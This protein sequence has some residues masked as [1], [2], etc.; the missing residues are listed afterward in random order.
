MKPAAL[1]L[2]FCIA[3]Q[4]HADRIEGVA[5][6]LYHGDHD[7]L[8]AVDEIAALGASHVSLAVFWRQRDVRSSSLGPDPKV[9]IA[10]DR[11]RA[12]VRRAHER[13]L[14]VLLFPII[15][16]DV[17]KRGEWRG[18]LAPA[19]REAW[20]RSYETFILHYARLAAEEKIAI[21]SVGS[22]LGS[23][24][25]WQGRWWH[26][27]GK[28]ERLYAGELLYSANWDHYRAPTFWQRL[29]YVGVSAYF[30]L[31]KRRDAPREELAT[32][33]QTALAEIGRFAASVEKR[34]VLTEVGLPSR[35]G[36]AMAPWDYTREGPIDLEEQRLGYQAFLD[37]WAKERIAGA[38][39]WHW[40][41]AGGP[42]DGGYSPRGKPAAE[43]LRRA[44]GGTGILAP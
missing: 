37:A 3:S 36:A 18:T 13:K 32:A 35:D 25:S 2:L 19:D 39:F 30:D 44:Y 26:L 38:F 6:P 41:G 42:D 27:I 1:A 16:L 9:T 10:D 5:L 20:W 14:A 24:E 31:T 12:I 15:E 34:V 17:V 21:L 28:I 4:A 8:H 22:E 40:F 7:F 33:W 11:L 23:T 29:D 43:V